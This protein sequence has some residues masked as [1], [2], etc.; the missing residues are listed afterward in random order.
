MVCCKPIIEEKQNSRTEAVRET[1]EA[2]F[3]CF[4]ERKDWNTFCSFYTTDMSFEDVSLQVQLDSLWQF[5]RFYNWPDT[6][7]VFKK[8]SDDQAHLELSSLV[9]DESIAVGRGHFNPFRYNGELI[10]ADWGMDFTIWLY[11]DEK[12]KIKK[13]VDWIEYD[14]YTLES[15]IKRCRKYGHEKTPTWLDLSRPESPLSTN[16]NPE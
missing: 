2:F 7:N 15:T 11:F 16:D 13:Q 6:V 1:A 4:A 9:A 12:L 5:K 8:L 3:E 10:K 14:S